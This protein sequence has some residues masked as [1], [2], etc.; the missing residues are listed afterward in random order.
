MESRR[1]WSVCEQNHL[2]ERKMNP[3]KPIALTAILSGSLAAFSSALIASDDGM[4]SSTNWQ[5]WNN[6]VSQAS[7]E[8]ASKGS[9]GM[10]ASTNWQSWNVYMAEPNVQQNT[11]R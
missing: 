10:P 3:I 2:E 9:K 1:A 11:A 6:Y 8:Q 4:P 5:T 7:Q